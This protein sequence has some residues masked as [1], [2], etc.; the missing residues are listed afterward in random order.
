LHIDGRAAVAM[1]DGVVVA[2][3]ARPQ[4]VGGRRGPGQ[5]WIGV[6][7]K[8]GTLQ[9]HW[10]FVLRPGDEEVADLDVLAVDGAGSLLVAGVAPDGRSR[11]VQ[12]DGHGTPQRRVDLGT[13]RVAHIAPAA[14]GGLWIAGGRDQ[15]QAFVGRLAV[16]GCFTELP[17]AGQG[18]DSL[19]VDSGPM[20]GG[21]LMLLENRGVRDL[22]FMRDS[23]LVLTLLR[24]DAGA[25]PNSFSM[26]GRG[27]SVVKTSDGF[28]L[29][30]DAGQG[31]D[32]QLRWL[33]L[34]GRLHIVAEADIAILRMGLERSRMVELPG[35]RYLVA[36]AHPSALRCWMLDA[37]GQVLGECR[38]PER[39]GFVRATL[40]SARD[41]FV[42]ATRISVDASGKPRH[43]LFV[44]KFSGSAR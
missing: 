9:R 12:M 14:D 42:V 34:D 1:G 19:V 44:A 26:P 6:I 5:G 10:T 33:R 28:A 27:G 15:R 36:A 25:D 21:G 2:G 35:D 23:T 31:V 13:R 43:D 29:L 39:A 8:D 30:V 37:R 20:P 11:L 17:P 40:V 41:A 16:D 38:L 22:F 18:P 24:A 7:D 32:Q 3:L 4:A